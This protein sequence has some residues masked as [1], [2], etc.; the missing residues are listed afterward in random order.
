MLFLKDRCFPSEQTQCQPL[1]CMRAHTYCLF[2]CVR[3][4]WGLVHSIYH[5]DHRNHTQVISLG[6]MHP[7]PLSHL[8]RSTRTLL[9]QHLPHCKDG[10][11]LIWSLFLLPEGAPI[12]LH[13]PH[14]LG[15]LGSPELYPHLCLCRLPGL[16]LP[17]TERSCPVT[18][19]LDCRRFI[20]IMD[21]EVLLPISWPSN[22]PLFAGHLCVSVL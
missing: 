21:C 1:G 13:L 12:Y 10:L 6:H 3:T 9:R 5:M 4:T 18:F 8:T 16:C 2:K 15:L 20:P 17:C 19:A 22:I 7:D 11:C 14:P